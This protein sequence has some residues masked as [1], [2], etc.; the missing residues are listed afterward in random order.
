MNKKIITSTKKQRIF[1]GF[2]KAIE[3]EKN[4]QTKWMN[5]DLS[6]KNGWF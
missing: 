4:K 1:M 2:L 6:K 3:E 5:E